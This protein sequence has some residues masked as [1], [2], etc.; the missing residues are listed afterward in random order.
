MDLI[1][2]LIIGLEV[3]SNGPARFLPGRML[4]KSRFKNV[5]YKYD[6]CVFFL[7]QLEGKVQQG[8]RDFEQ[9][10]KTIRKEVSRFEVRACGE[11]YSLER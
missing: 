3:N 9:I 8:E 4:Q 11:W 10:S 2:D 5:N 6:V 1:I 7:F